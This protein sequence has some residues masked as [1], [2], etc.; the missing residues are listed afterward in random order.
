MAETARV[1]SREPR[2]MNHAM[3]SK[4]I[5]RESTSA[6]PLTQVYTLLV[7]YPL[8]ILNEKISH[9]WNIVRALKGA[10]ITGQSGI[11]YK[12]YQVQ[13]TALLRASSKVRLSWT[14][15]LLSQFAL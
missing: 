3:L 10:Y 11:Q 1:V 12:V 13:Y 5:E 4:P 7:F 15:R 9:V 14:S 6:H 8:T 2:V